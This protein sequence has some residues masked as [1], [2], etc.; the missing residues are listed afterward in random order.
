MIV[1]VVMKK[2][3][4][5]SS[6]LLLIV[7][8]SVTLCLSG[9]GHTS[10]ET[11]GVF[12]QTAYYDNYPIQVIDIHFHPSNGWESVGPLGKEFILKELPSWLPGPLKTLGVKV[13]S[14]LIN[15]PYGAFG[16]K[17][18][19]QAAGI[20][21]CGLF[22]TYAP[23]TWGIVSNQ[24]IIE[25]LEDDRNPNNTLGKKLFF[26]L[27][28][29]D[30]NDWETTKGEKLKNLEESLR[31]NLIKGI[32]MAH[33]HNNVPL[34]R[35]GFEGIYELANQ[36]KVPVYHHVGSTPL[37]KLEDFGSNT[38]KSDYIRSYDP[39][40]LEDLI[41]KYPNIPF[42]LGHMGFDFNAEGYDFTDDA[43][44]LAQAYPNVFLEI[45]AMGRPIFDETGLVLDHAFNRIKSKNLINKVIYGSDGPV[46]PGA[47]KAYL[48]S[49]MNSMSRMDYNYDEA[50]KVLFHN[51]NMIFKVY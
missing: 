22:A 26:G 13:A 27:A 11:S 30:I 48:N 10:N 24:F 25:A 43:I 29:I 45:S 12:Q 17:K 9:T 15:S 23:D 51:A 4:K 38:E 35:K 42:I 1:E 14:S 40:M 34:D 28:S 16:I 41:E 44:A 47:T 36:Y 8:V 32:K 37:R 20:S 46:Y 19:C 6:S 3:R 18:E 31:N 21:F 50:Q 33:I 7:G 49:V 5:L 2:I 39:V